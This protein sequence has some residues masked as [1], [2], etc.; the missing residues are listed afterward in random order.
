MEGSGGR[1]K[2][3]HELKMGSVGK[4]GARNPVHPPKSNPFPSLAHPSQR[5][6]G[7]GHAGTVELSPRQKLDVSWLHLLSWSAKCKATNSCTTRKHIAVSYPPCVTIHFPWHS[8]TDAASSSSCRPTIENSHKVFIA[9]I[10][11]HMQIA[12]AGLPC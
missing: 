7:S 10:Q 8:S 1:R 2:G 9:L 3:C 5:E 11:V 12:V 4:N 6:E